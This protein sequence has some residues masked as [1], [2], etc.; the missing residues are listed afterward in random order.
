MKP[1]TF[2]VLRT[3]EIVVCEDVKD[4]RVIEDVEYLTVHKEN[5]QR[6]FLMRKDALEKVSIK[7]KVSL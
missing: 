1:I 2:K 6:S 7:K 4:I 3:N 5:N